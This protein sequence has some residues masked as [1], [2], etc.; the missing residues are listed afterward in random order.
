VSLRRFAWVA[1]FSAACSAVQLFAASPAVGVVEYVEGD[2]TL[3]R[4]GVVRGTPEPGDSVENFDFL[5]TGPN[6]LVVV[7]LDKASGMFGTLTVR[8]KS[9]FSVKTEIVKGAPATEADMIAGAVAVKAEKLSGAPSLRVRTTATT[10]GVRG[11]EFEVAV[12]VND[13]LLVS[14]SSGVVACTDAEGE[15]L[16]AVPGQSFVRSAGERLR[17]VPVAVT[18]LEA[19]KKDWLAEELRVFAAAP[20]RAVDQYAV[21]YRRMK[22]DFEAAS[23]RLSGDPGLSEWTDQFRRG[24]TP[25]STDVRV[26]RQKSALVPKLMGV[27]RVL[28]LLERVYYRLSDIRDQVGPEVLSARLPSGGTIAAFFRELDRDGPDLEKKAA[29]F[30]FALRLYAERNDGRDAVSLGEDGGG[31]FDDA[32]DFFKE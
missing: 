16:E 18:G 7:A 4:A 26:M 27:R 30:R 19:F 22:G 23:T 21:R 5:R 20:V 15:E 28:F 9:A 25:R 12:S 29:S 11:T 1:L 3:T 6:G 10:M 14:C 2:V 13:S 31:F 32:S 24:T 8:P 17:R